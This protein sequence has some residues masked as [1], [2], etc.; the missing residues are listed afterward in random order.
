[1]WPQQ[2]LV[3]ATHLCSMSGKDEEHHVNHAVLVTIVL[4]KVH[5][6]VGSIDDVAGQLSGIVTAFSIVL[7]PIDLDRA[8]DVELGFEHTHRV[9]SEIVSH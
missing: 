2:T 5:F 3:V 9:I 8:N 4:A 6:A 7:A 1:M